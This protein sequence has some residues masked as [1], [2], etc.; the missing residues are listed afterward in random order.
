MDTT[1]HRLILFTTLLGTIGL[2]AASAQISAE[3]EQPR[4][5]KVPEA[6]RYRVSF[7]DKSHNTY[8]TKRPEEFL[9]TK[10][11][12]RRRKYKIKVDEY[13]LPV[14][15]VYLDY[16]SSQGFRVI[17]KSK[18]NNTAIVETS[19]T[20]AIKQLA[21]ISY[22]TAVK[23]VW[24]SP[25]SIAVPTVR[26]RH[27][28][29]VTQYDTLKTHYGHAQH[30]VSMI[31]VDKLHQAGFT[32]EG[33]T[34]AVID[35][36][37]YNAD[38]IA[39]LSKARILGTHNF[40]HPDE[41]VYMAQPHGTMV[42][43]C[44][45]ANVS[46]SLVGTAPQANFY[47]LMSEDAAGENMIEEDYWCAAAEYADSIGADIV[48]SSLGYYEFDDHS[49]SHK[50][51]EL[52]GQT[53]ANSRAASL[54]ASRGLL[55]LNSA[56]N[57]GDEEWK[58]IGFPADARDILTVGA[59]N[60]D[61]HNTVFSS[62]GNTAD[63]R[64]KPDVMAMGQSVWLYGLDGGVTTANGTSFS[65]PLLC[66]GVACLLQACPKARPEEIIR[67]V[68]LSGNNAKHPDNIYGYGIPDLWR[69]LS[70]LRK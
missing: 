39:G 30:Q 61:G 58:K 52:D 1:L 15:A 17:S 67:A 60:E 54:A 50:Y 29:L 23:R 13:D 3:V 44:I 21:D 59:V 70:L 11:L 41:D 65:T 19:D 56:G 69:A 43:S 14:S 68:Q 45:A 34:V 57:S 7:K 24:S 22:V 26:D 9:S 40:V 32:G 6:H 20:V 31:G 33:V 5:V 8:T 35:G 62:V 63:G 2:A 25:D 27:E 64:I 48:T 55:V 18:W 37:F 46:G 49:A 66:G 12:E 4:Y 16:L 47:L 28:G 42:L 36:G 38:C 53:A 10:A 51:Y